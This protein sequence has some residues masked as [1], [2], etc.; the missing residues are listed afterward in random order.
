[1]LQ[2]SQP[3]ADTVFKITFSFHNNIFSLIKRKGSPDPAT[4]SS[5]Q[6]ASFYNLLKSNEIKVVVVVVVV[7]E[8]V[9]VV[10][11]VVVDVVPAAAGGVVAAAEVTLVLVY[12]YSPVSP[13]SSVLLSSFI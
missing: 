10:V 8:V 2:S 12:S 9:V 11:I 3:N 7:V 6:F 1:M 13:R 4:S 5:N